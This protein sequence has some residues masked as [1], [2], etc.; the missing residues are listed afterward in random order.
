MASCRHIN[1]TW[2]ADFVMDALA[3]P[4][5]RQ[6]IGGASPSNGL[7]ADLAAIALTLTD[8][9]T[10]VWLDPLLARNEAVV[11]WLRFQRGCWGD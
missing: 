4:G 7:G 3:N 9:D 1:D 5:L 2:S 6:T 11:A 8:H 10:P